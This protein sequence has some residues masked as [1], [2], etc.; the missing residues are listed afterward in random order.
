MVLHARSDTAKEIEILVLRHQLTVLQRRKP[1]PR[2]SL[3]DR[4]V[5]TAL[6]RLRPTR[7]RL[8]LLVTP[9][10][11]LHWHRRL[12]SRRWTTQPVR[13]GRPAIP[14]GVRALI[15]RLAGENPTWAIGAST[16]SSPDLATRSAPRRSGRSCARRGSIPYRSGPDRLGA[17]PPGAGPRHHACDLFH[18]DTIIAHP[19]GEWL[20]QQARNL[21]M[22]LDD[23]GRRF[24]FLIRDR[25]TKLP[26]MPSSPRSTSR[27]SRHRCGHLGPTRSPNASWAQSGANSSTAP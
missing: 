9:S 2:T 4:A 20:T 1:Q 19:T 26:S 18:L 3:T 13:A 25:D 14:A 22:D 8:G 11:I 23:A 15:L 16:A 12:V 10:T 7:R 5:I 24:Q 6:T 21:V 27:S 17:V